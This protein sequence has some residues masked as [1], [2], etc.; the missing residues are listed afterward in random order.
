MSIQLSYIVSTYNDVTRLPCL[1]H[2]LMVQT[3]AQFEIIVT[4][5]S[6]DAVAALEIAAI[7]RDVSHKIRYYHCKL[8]SC[9]DSADFGAQ[10]ARG[11]FV[12]FPS[13]DSYYMP[14]FGELM[15]AGGYHADLVY[16]DIVYD[17]RNGHGRYAVTDA[18][19]CTGW[20]DKTQFIVRKS[21]FPGFLVNQTEA[22][23]VSDGKLIEELVRR[24]VSH[25]KIT[26]VL[27]VHN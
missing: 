14:T 1:L 9:Y 4:D 25:K 15:L 17:A 2:S 21:V 22:A 12:C 23:P 10:L 27:G 26:D 7:C 8:A 5:N 18:Q 3:N 20:I 19:P 16:C 11:E 6:D 24:G 13:D